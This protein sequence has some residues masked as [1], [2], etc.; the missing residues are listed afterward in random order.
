VINWICSMGWR[1][2]LYR[3]YVTVT[4]KEEMGNYPSVKAAYFALCGPKQSM[5]HNPT[6]AK[7]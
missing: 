1:I 7:P 3:D 6:W 2:T 4:K 5:A